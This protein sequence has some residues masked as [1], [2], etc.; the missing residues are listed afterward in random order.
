[1]VSSANGICCHLGGVAFH[2]T[3]LPLRTTRTAGSKHI[4]PS[5]HLQLA[6]SLLRPNLPILSLTQI[7]DRGWQKWLNASIT[8]YPAEVPNSSRRDRWRGGALGPPEQF[9][10]RQR[11]NGCVCLYTLCMSVSLRSTCAMCQPVSSTCGGYGMQHLGQCEF[12]R[13]LC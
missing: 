10:T 4:D 12:R 2:C 11:L 5:R 8:G 6:K 3:V 7:R 1:M 9:P 13:A